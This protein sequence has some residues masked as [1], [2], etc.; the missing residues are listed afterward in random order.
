MQSS[1]RPEGN[2]KI[3]TECIQDAIKFREDGDT[4]SKDGHLRLARS[5]QCHRPQ[6]LFSF[7]QRIQT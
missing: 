7:D 1:E 6:V 3:V 2:S 4:P 5:Y